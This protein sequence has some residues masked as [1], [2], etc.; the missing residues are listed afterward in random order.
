MITLTIPK[1]RISDFVAEITRLNKKLIRKGGNDIEYVFGEDTIVQQFVNIFHD[2]GEFSHSQ[3]QSVPATIVE[4]TGDP[5]HISGYEI[6]GVLED[7]SEGVRIVSGDVDRIPSEFI[8]SVDVCLCQHCYV[9]RARKHIVLLENTDGAIIQVGK[10]CLKDFV[11]T[12]TASYLSRF[13]I[14]HSFI[15]EWNDDIHVNFEN[16]SGS[17][18]PTDEV[19]CAAFQIITRDG[20]FVKSSDYGS[21]R[22]QVYDMLVTQNRLNLHMGAEAFVIR[23]FWREMNTSSDFEDKARLRMISEV[24]HTSD[25]GIIAAAVWGYVRDMKKQDDQQKTYEWI[26]TLGERIDLTVTINKSMTFQQFHGAIRII[27]A[28]DSNGNKIKI[29][30]TGKFNPVEGKTINIKGTVKK[31]GFYSNIKQTELSRVVIS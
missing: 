3:L 12:D 18:F 11:G 15:K 31:H 28:T 4:I 23:H 8:Y 10:T 19:V 29:K 17:Y 5:I 6:I 30:S 22:D 20:K 7:T 16:Y 14:I 1:L 26:G 25:F 13:E 27:I 24:A 21:T 9:N 2:D